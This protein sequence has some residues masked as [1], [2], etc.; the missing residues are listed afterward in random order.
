MK[1]AIHTSHVDLDEIS[2]IG[3]LKKGPN[4]NWVFGVMWKRTGNVG[5]IDASP[6]TEVRDRYALDGVDASKPAAE[7]AYQE[8]LDRWYNRPEINQDRIQA[9]NAHV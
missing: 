4:G 2:M 9:A 6:E 1:I 5:N 7:L 3:P 8:F